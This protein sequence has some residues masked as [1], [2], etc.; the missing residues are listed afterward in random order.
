MVPMDLDLE[1]IAIG[2]LVVV[3]IGAILCFNL[4]V[5]DGLLGNEDGLSDN[6][7][8]TTT[9]TT[10]GV[11]QETEIIPSMTYTTVLDGLSW[12]SSNTDVLKIT[13]DPNSTY[14]TVIIEGLSE[15][16]S[17]VTASYGS[18]TRT[19][20]VTV[21]TEAPDNELRVYNDNSE[22]NRYVLLTGS[23][24]ESGV[25]S[26]SFN[27]GGRAVVTMSG[28]T[29]SML[30]AN[31]KL[32]GG[33]YD[34]KKVVM[35]ATDTTTG[36]IKVQSIY[37]GE[38]RDSSL[39]LNLGT[40]SVN[41][42]Y[43][44]DF[45]VTPYYDGSPYHVTGTLEYKENDG[46]KDSTAIFKRPYA[47]RYGGAEYAFDLE[48]SYGDY[49]RYHTNALSG[50]YRTAWGD[51]WNRSSSENTSDFVR[52][53]ESLNQ[54][55]SALE[56]LYLEKYGNNASLTS[57]SYANFIMAFV[58][59]CWYYTYDEVQYTGGSSGEYFSYPMETVYSGCGDCDDTT[60]LA[61]SLFK[62]AGYKAGTYSLPGH[63]MAAV[64][65]DNYEL[66]SYDS[67]YYAYMAYYIDD[68]DMLYYGCETTVDT[69]RPVGIAN[70]SVLF[71]EYGNRYNNVKL[72]R[73]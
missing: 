39:L 61:A 64:H 24:F 68:P 62:G 20:T 66:P 8:L 2:G 34:L 58:Q 69:F 9:A 12:S 45:F 48:F 71:D 14:G 19:C 27:V 4:G 54:V 73:L 36:T 23:G 37:D 49:S 50:S 17:T 7:E 15:G 3:V 31:P 56:Q 28:Y 21:Q 16:T 25:L 38:D 6:F 35:T 44:I 32:I 65:I 60:V 13:K 47:W 43:D 57:T 67:N 41:T 52:N 70:K 59:I 18:C 26:F 30:D 72:Y 51:V 1:G 10:I 5:F 42:P 46:S 40:L 29:K 22:S 55:N 53:N 11:G 63:A 33:I